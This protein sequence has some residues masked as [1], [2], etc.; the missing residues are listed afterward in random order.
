[1]NLI[2]PDDRARWLLH[3]LGPDDGGLAAQCAL[4]GIRPE[5]LSLELAGQNVLSRLRGGESVG[6]VLARM[7]QM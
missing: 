7:Q 5:Q 6:S 3:G 1:M 2:D 4:A